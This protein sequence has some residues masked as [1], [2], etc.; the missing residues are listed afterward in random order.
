MSKKLFA[1]CSIMAT[2]LLSSC[3][4]TNSELPKKESSNVEESTVR[5]SEVNAEGRVIYDDE[6]LKATYSI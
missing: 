1:L 4:S 6:I 2:V 5:E 3:S